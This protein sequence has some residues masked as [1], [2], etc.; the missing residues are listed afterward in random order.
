MRLSV[1]FVQQMRL[2]AAAAAAARQQA[3]GHTQQQQLHQLQREVL[4]ET[5]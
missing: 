1:P 2:P 4:L 3:E 5:P